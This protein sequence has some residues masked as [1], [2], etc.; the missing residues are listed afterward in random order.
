MI[1]KVTDLE[2]LLERV[3]KELVKHKDGSESVHFT[4]DKEGS[5][6]VIDKGQ[7]TEQKMSSRERKKRTKGAV[8]SKYHQK[9]ITKVNKAAEKR[10]RERRSK[11][12]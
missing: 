11:N 4:S 6:V 10:I 2:N 3:K 5:K 12:V 8:S 9:G 7:P 1:C